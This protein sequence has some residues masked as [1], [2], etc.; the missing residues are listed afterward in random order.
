MQNRDLYKNIC[1]H[2]LIFALLCLSSFIFIFFEQAHFDSDQAISGLMAKHLSEGRHFPIFTYGAKYVLGFETWLAAPFMAIWGASV[3]TLKLPLLLLNALTAFLLIHLFKREEKLSSAWIFLSLL[4]LIFPAPVTA[5]RVIH[6]AIGVPTSFL[7]CV[8]VWLLWRRPIGLGILLGFVIPI[9]PFLLY[10]AAAMFVL[11]WMEGKLFLR[12]NIKKWMKVGTITVGLG[13]LIKI[14]GTSGPNYSGPSVPGFVIKDPVTLAKSVSWLF[15]ENLSTL[16]GLK[17]TRLLD[18]NVTSTLT[19]GS[20]FGWALFSI[21][22]VVFLIRS[23]KARWAHLR[24]SLLNHRF[25]SFLMLTGLISAVVYTCLTRNAE[26]I[27]LIRYTLMSLFLPIGF[28]AYYSKTEGNPRWKQALATLV[29]LWFGQNL[30]DHARFIR[31][32]AFTPTANQ[33]RELSN[34]LES[35]SIRYGQAGFW[36]SVHT[37]FFSGEKVL[38][39]E[40][41]F[42]RIGEY[43]RRISEH[44]EEMVTILDRPCTTTD[45]GQTIRDWCILSPPQR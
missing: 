35:H 25:S 1:F 15:S 5:S 30:F 21:A 22:I 44:P 7:A 20:Y 18:F 39:T 23:F 29:I 37:T 2:F 4:F 40:T 33:Y 31:E 13:L 27:M 34:F 26:N 10:A 42:A 43:K 28:V 3:A 12:E 9:R 6:A 11:E 45:P 24:T 32:Y 36:T 8:L 16:F 17:P 14:W 41:D 19:T 38:L